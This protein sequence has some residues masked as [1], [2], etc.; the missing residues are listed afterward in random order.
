MSLSTYAFIAVGGATGACLRFFLYEMA[1]KLFGKGFPFGTLL[2]NVFGSLLIGVL[3]AAAEQGLTE[4]IPWRNLVGIGF[5]GALTTFSTFSLDTVLLMQ[6]G[7]WLKAVLN[8]L[9]NVS[10]CILAAF[11]GIKLVVVKTV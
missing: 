2:V 6:Q 8:V 11:I 5:L 3:Y 9:L 10:M 7:F 4:V 1:I